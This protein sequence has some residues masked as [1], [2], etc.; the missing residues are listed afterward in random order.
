MQTFCKTHILAL[1]QVLKQ[2]GVQV[3]PEQSSIL[4]RFTGS[5]LAKWFK[6]R[7]KQVKGKQR[8]SLGTLFKPVDVPMNQSLD[9]LGI[10]LSYGN[11]EDLTLERRKQ[12]AR[13]S[14]VRLSKFLFSRK[15]LTLKRRVR[16]YATCVR[17]SLLYGLSGVGFNYHKRFSGTTTL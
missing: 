7:I 17:S 1:L 3:N 12:A 8:L 9:Y 15:G 16:M 10:T 6:S 2:A 13:A 14:V 11:F 5:Q 4:L